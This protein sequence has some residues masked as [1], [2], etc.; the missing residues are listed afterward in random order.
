LRRWRSRRPEATG[1]GLAP[2]S[3]AK[4]P[5]VTESV[6]VLVSGDQEL[7]GV[8]GGDREQLRGARRG[9]GDKG[10]EVRVERGDLVVEFADS[11]GE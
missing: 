1:I 11:A 9:G 10:L 3:A 8:A 7:A 2:Q 5:S 4:A 6:D